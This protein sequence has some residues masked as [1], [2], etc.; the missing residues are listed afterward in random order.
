MKRFKLPWRRKKRAEQAKRRP[1][2]PA[3]ASGSGA[4][5]V[6]SPAGTPYSAPQQRE[7]LERLRS[8]GYL[9]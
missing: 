4:A 8:L 5:T 7:V 6:G 9:G 1:K 2:A 3:A